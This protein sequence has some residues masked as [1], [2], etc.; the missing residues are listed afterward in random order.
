MIRYVIYNPLNELAF[1]R[2]ISSLNTVVWGG[3]VRSF[4][5]ED[6]AHTYLS[7]LACRGFEAWNWDV[8]PE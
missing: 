3:R 5:N 4:P 7:F 6:Q 1:S 2:L 8:R